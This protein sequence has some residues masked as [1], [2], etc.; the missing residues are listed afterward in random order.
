MA[1]TDF[2]G[3]RKHCRDPLSEERT[4]I[5]LIDI[6]RAYFNAKTN[7]DDPVYVQFPPEMNM[8]SSQCGLLRRHMYGTRR[9]AEGW[10]DEY[11]GTMVSMGFT[12]G[13]ASACVF[14]HAERHIAVSVHG[15]DFTA[16]GPKRQLDW[17]EERMR[18]HYELTV[19]GRLGPGPRTMTRKPL[20]S[21]ASSGGLSNGIEYEADPTPGRTAPR[22]DRA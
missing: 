13:K 7:A 1:A 12:Q 17:F 9:A 5:L 10:Q 11:S 14:M 16:T 6:S 20:S 18:Q 21:T 3:A 2:A 4:Q 15:D 22:G 19:G 8:D